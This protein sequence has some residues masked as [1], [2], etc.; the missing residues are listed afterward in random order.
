MLEELSKKLEAGASSSKD[1]SGGAKYIVESNA[2]AVFHASNHNPLGL[3]Q[4]PKLSHIAQDTRS[5]VAKVGNISRLQL[6]VEASLQPESLVACQ[7][8][9]ANLRRTRPINSSLMKRP[10]SRC[11]GYCARPKPSKVPKTAWEVAR[12]HLLN[13]HMI[14]ALEPLKLLG[15]YE[16]RVPGVFMHPYYVIQ[17]LQQLTPPEQVTILHFHHP[18]PRV[19][20]L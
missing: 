12:G 6:P 16:T 4:V 2:A 3:K 11:H 14:L 17:M 1:G 8:M 18:P 5:V 9:P 20:V 15:E 19:R 7:M 13:W 10:A